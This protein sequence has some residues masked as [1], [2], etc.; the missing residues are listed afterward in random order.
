[1]PNCNT[2]EI[3]VKKNT[4][5]EMLNWCEMLKENQRWIGL[6]ADNIQFLIYPHLH[7]SWS[8]NVNILMS[9][10]HA[11]IHTQTNGG[12]WTNKRH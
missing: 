3:K 5:F 2:L 6:N 9:Y 12:G 4:Y 7:S 8:E 10:T 11:H 1:M